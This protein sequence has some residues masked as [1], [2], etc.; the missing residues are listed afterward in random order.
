MVNNK[1]IVAL[2]LLTL[3]GGII[4]FNVLKT[5][6]DEKS[7]DTTL[8]DSTT[9]ESPITL[10]ELISLFRTDK[11]FQPTDVAVDGRE[12]ETI[13][14]EEESKWDELISAFTSGFFNP[15]ETL[16]GT[17][18]DTS[19]KTE[20]GEGIIDKLLNFFKQDDVGEKK[21]SDISD[22][23]PKDIDSQG[24]VGGESITQAFLRGLFNPIDTLKD[25]SSD[26][27]RQIL[28]RFSDGITDQDLNN[29]KS[30]L[31][32]DARDPF[33]TTGESSKDRDRRVSD[34]SRRTDP[35]LTEQL[36]S[37]SLQA[38]LIEE[39]QPGFFSD[40]FKE[41]AESLNIAI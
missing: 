3:G 8:P 30:D 12:Q 29:L 25:V 33:Q 4:A 39:K 21:K 28:S 34:I 15:I 9:G 17:P 6:K 20:D 10:D 31:S 23:Q 22:V 18:K 7:T 41:K 27:I 32:S 24:V 19:S 1:T 40:A 14:T 26:D 35:T 5:P 11:D 13:T 37:A 38:K 16:I 2:G 36:G